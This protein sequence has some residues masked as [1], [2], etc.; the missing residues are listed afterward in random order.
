MGWEHLLMLI[1]ALHAVWSYN[2]VVLPWGS[3]SVIT[4][5]WYV[6][7]GVHYFTGTSGTQTIARENKSHLCNKPKQTVPNGDGCEGW[8]LGIAMATAAVF[9]HITG[10]TV[11]VHWWWCCLSFTAKEKIIWVSPC[12][13]RRCCSWP[14]RTGGPPGNSISYVPL[15]VLFCSP[16]QWSY[17]AHSVYC[18][19]FQRT[20]EDK[21]EKALSFIYKTHGELM[22]KAGLDMCKGSLMDF[23]PFSKTIFAV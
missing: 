15:K 1:T 10:E 6:R 16:L 5:N 12:H 14:R 22:Q 13:G 11:K 9:S 2:D 23:W 18:W 20:E 7:N 4:D 8:S 3:G 21:R 17:P 19:W